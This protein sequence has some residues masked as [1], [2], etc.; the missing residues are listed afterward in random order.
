VI[1][2]RSSDM[3]SQLSWPFTGREDELEWMAAARRDPACRGGMVSG[4]A[5][6]GK[7]RLARE[8]LAA[9]RTDGAA[10]EWV[11]ATAAAASI[12]LGPFADL[13]PVGAHTG[14]RLHLFQLC[15]ETLRA[16]AAGKRLLLGVDDAHLLDPTSAALVLHLAMNGTAF[17]VVTVRAGERCPDPIVALWK[18]LEVP[19]LELQQ[20]SEDETADLLEM[21]LEGQLA[22]SVVR[23]AFGTSEGHPLYL[24]ELVKGALVSGA[25]VH[26]GSLWQLGSRPA[27]SPALVDLIS[28]SLEGLGAEEL[29]TAR[30]LALGEPLELDIVT[31]LGGLPSLSALEARELAVVAPPVAPAGTTQV[32]LSHP[33]YGEVV[34]AKTP[35]LQATALRLRLAETVRANRLARPGDALRVAT[36]LLEAGAPIDQPLLL[37]AAREANAAGDPD[38]AARLAQRALN[39]GAGGTEAILI[40]AHADVLRRRFAE[41]ED[42]LAGLEDAPLTGEL[43]VAYLEERAVRVLHLGLQR[44][45]EALGVLARAQGW[46]A[47]AGWRDRV[48]L[49]R[50]Q[51][52]LTSP[53]TGPAEAA[54]ALDRLLQQQAELIPEARRRAAILYALALYQLGRTA[55]ARAVSERLRPTVPLRDGDDAWALMAWWAPRHVA[56]CEWAETERWLL[57]ADRTSARANDPLTC[58]ELAMLIASSAIRRGKP[59]TAT[60][61]ARE[62][63]EILERSDTA[64]RLPIA[65]LCLVAGTATGGDLEAARAALAGYW[66]SIGGSSFPPLLRQETTAL[67]ALAVAEGETSRAVAMLL[68]AAAKSAGSPL[69]Q[70]HLLHHALRAGAAPQTVAPRLHAAAAACDAPLAAS[71]ARVATALAEGDGQA[72][73]GEAQT[74]GE[75]GAWLW[76]AET[77]AQAAVAYTHAGRDDSARRAIALSARFY[78]DCE[79]S[80]SPVLAAVQLAPAELTRRELEIVTL[81]ARGSSNAEIAERLVLSIRTVESHLYRA[82]R[83]LGVS[84]RQDLGAHQSH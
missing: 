28:L 53:G 56:G 69:D 18:D 54:D 75:I 21:A 3:V 24:R 65:W 33:L 36:W 43:A 74:L 38:L 6:V 12:P 49:L 15:A 81:A 8:A 32:R 1:K 72:L 59:I 17:V 62:A 30:L 46:S 68:D 77:A 80:L 51:V 58:G 84:T 25:L 60:K 35:T 14:D 11:Q 66:R 55:D 10:I 52:L 70:A 9:V 50:S 73:A 7:T 41:A 16:R 61:R 13:V 29:D 19:R 31:R 42:L 76:A 78:E 4:T 20:L 82:M 47:D 44:S 23:W 37:A 57:D 64:R 5:G 79:G 39:G 45:G 40:L 27:P 26:R 67:A 22:P 63:I 48:D 34:R 71:F 83:K 2:G